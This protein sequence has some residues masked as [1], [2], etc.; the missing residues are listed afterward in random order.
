[1]PE[2]KAMIGMFVN[3]LPYRIKLKSRESFI[4]LMLQVRRLCID[5]L[6]HARLPYQ[7]IIHSVSKSSPPKIPFFFQYES[8]MSSITYGS[9]IEPTTKDA[10]MRLYPGRDW[11]HGNGTALNDLSL[12][13]THNYHDRTTH[14][15]FECS[16]DVYDLPMISLMARC[17]QYLISQ[18]FSSVGIPQLNRTD[19][20]I[21]ELSLL[22][23]EDRDDIQRTAFY[24]LPSVA[25]IGM[26]FSKSLEYFHFKI[27]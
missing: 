19:D 26:S 17:F 11:S 21:S 10:I 14:F 22:L 1:L 18:I 8:T 25:N 16:A 15:I 12:T 2:T 24:R 3:L 23:P 20:P 9:T 7:E 13:M 5:V 27:E 4:N 6:E